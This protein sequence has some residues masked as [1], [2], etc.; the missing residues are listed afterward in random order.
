MLTDWKDLKFFQQKQAGELLPE[1]TEVPSGLKS[2]V[3]SISSLPSASAKIS[4]V[5]ISERT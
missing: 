5:Q 4:K 3:N 1:M 2:C